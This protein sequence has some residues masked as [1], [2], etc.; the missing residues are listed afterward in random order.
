MATAG[1]IIPFV[2]VYHPDVPIVL[3]FGPLNSIW[4]IVAFGLGTWSLSSALT[5]YDTAVPPAWER[6]VRA[7]AALLVPA[8]AVAL[9]AAVAAGAPI[10]RPYPR[11]RAAVNPLTPGRFPVK[12]E[13]P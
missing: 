5:G 12:E 7:A 10:A 8:L 3:G 4:P 2:F 1:F 11:G 6:V 9:P 13:T